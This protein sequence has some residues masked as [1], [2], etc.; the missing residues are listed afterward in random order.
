MSYRRRLPSALA[1]TLP[2]SATEGLFRGLQ[3]VKR[4]QRVFQ[5]RVLDGEYYQDLFRYARNMSDIPVSRYL[6]DFFVRCRFYGVIE[7]YLHLIILMKAEM[8]DKGIFSLLKLAPGSEKYAFVGAVVGNH[9]GLA[10]GISKMYN[11]CWANISCLAYSGALWNCNE[12]ML[13]LLFE[14]GLRMSRDVA[15]K[16]GS[17]ICA[18]IDDLS[19]FIEMEI[20]H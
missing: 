16:I 15:D 19:R 14:I 20:D 1:K 6:E 7:I 11:K 5:D 2:V 17:K 10:R 8:N 9:V 4:I 18:P 12:E 3:S 13:G